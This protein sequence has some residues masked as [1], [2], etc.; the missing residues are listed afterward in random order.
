MNGGKMYAT[1]VMGWLFVTE[2]ENARAA[3]AM[4]KDCASGVSLLRSDV[5]SVRPATEDEIAWHKAMR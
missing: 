5:T 3:L 1:R 2:A 4:A